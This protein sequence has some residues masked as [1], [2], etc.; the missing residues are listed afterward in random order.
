MAHTGN[1]YFY[2]DCYN[3]K[4]CDGIDHREIIFKTDVICYTTV[5]TYCKHKSEYKG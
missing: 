3:D 5:K 1:R 2:F 4:D